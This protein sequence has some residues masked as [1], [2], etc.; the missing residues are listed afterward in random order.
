VARADPSLS[1]VESKKFHARGDAAY[2]GG[3]YADAV[4][5]YREAFKL[6]PKPALLY[7]I[8]YCEE[9][10]GDY[11]NA[12]LDYQRFI[13]A[14]PDHKKRS[15]VDAKLV[16]LPAKIGVALQ[17]SSSPPAA[18]IFVDGVL[19]GRSPSTLKVPAGHHRVRL[20]VEHAAP[21]EVEVDSKI[22]VVGSIDVVLPRSGTVDLQV[23]PPD[24]QIRRADQPDAQIGR[25]HAE[26]VPGSYHFSVRRPGYQDG[27]LDVAISGGEDIRQRVVLTRPEPRSGT[28]SVRAPAGAEVSIDARPA[29]ATSEVREQLAE[30]PHFVI[31]ERAGYGAWRGRVTVAAGQ[32]TELRVA[33][34]AEPSR[35]RTRATW[36]LGG[37]GLASLLAGGIVGVLALRDQAAYEHT[38]TRALG[39][40]AGSRALAADVLF[41]VGGA[42]LI[43]ALVLR[44]TG[45]SGEARARVSP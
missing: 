27:E 15:E 19:S 13:A 41:G 20:V 29:G 36:T 23:E 6:G 31:V 5:N 18:Q 17:V 21:R 22:G 42:A 2:D 35:L 28:L 11:E 10:L 25:Y 3:R 8:A 38:P 16:E 40:R 30:G 32:T 9:L 26:L 24:A 4:A 45:P 12:Y 43:S 1:E 14:A 7:N 39:D 33:L 44:W 37:V 34:S